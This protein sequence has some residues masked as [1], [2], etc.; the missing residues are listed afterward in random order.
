[1]N[2]ESA[3]FWEYIGNDIA[4]KYD[5]GHPKDWSIGKRRNFLQLMEKE[6]EEIF[7]ISRHK[8]E[9]CTQEYEKYTPISQKTIE[10]IFRTRITNGSIYNKNRFAILLGYENADEYIIK[11]EQIE[12]LEDSEEIDIN[13][14]EKYIHRKA[15]VDYQNKKG[16]KYIQSFNK[17][18]HLKDIYIQPQLVSESNNVY[19]ASLSGLMK[20]DDKITIHADS[21]TGKTTLLKYLAL[22]SKE[23]LNLLFLPLSDYRGDL[24]ALIRNTYGISEEQAKALTLK[25]ETTVL[26]LDAFD[27]IPS[28]ADRIK[29]ANHLSSDNIYKFIL[30]SRSKF[31]AD[32]QNPATLSIKIEDYQLDDIHLLVDKYFKSSGSIISFY[33]SLR[34]GTTYNKELE[35]LKY[36]W[37]VVFI[38]EHYTHG[39][40]LSHSFFT[41]IGLTIFEAIQ[42]KMWQNR[43][44]SESDVKRISIDI[45]G[46]LYPLWNDRNKDIIIEDGLLSSEQIQFLDELVHFGVINIFSLLNEGRKRYLFTI[47]LVSQIFIA[48]WMTSMD[49]KALSLTLSNIYFEPS[50]KKIIAYTAASKAS[51]GQELELFFQGNHLQLPKGVKNENPFYEQFMTLFILKH[52]PKGPFIKKNAPPL[53]ITPF[54]KQKRFNINKHLTDFYKVVGRFLKNNLATKRFETMMLTKQRKDILEYNLLNALEEKMMDYITFL[55]EK[56]EGLRDKFWNETEKIEYSDL[57]VTY[58][59]KIQRIRKS[60]IQTTSFKKKFFKL[61]QTKDLNRDDYI[62]ALTSSP[63]KAP[64]IIQQMWQQVRPLIYLTKF[65]PTRSNTSWLEN[66]NSGDK[67]WENHLDQ[68]Y[69]IILLLRKGEVTKEEIIFLFD[70]LS[71]YRASEEDLRVFQYHMGVFESTSLAK[72]LATFMLGILKKKEALIKYSSL[73]NLTSTST[74]FIEENLKLNTILNEI[75]DELIKVSI[76]IERDLK[77]KGWGGD[78]QEHISTLFSTDINI[79]FKSFLNLKK[80]PPIKNKVETLFERLLHLNQLGFKIYRDAFYHTTAYLINLESHFFL[81]KLT[82]NDYCRT[83]LINTLSNHLRNTDSWKNVLPSPEYVNELERFFL[84][85]NMADRDNSKKIILTLQEIYWSSKEERKY[86]NKYEEH[87]AKFEEENDTYELDQAC[88]YDAFEEYIKENTEEKYRKYALLHAIYNEKPLFFRADNT[89]TYYFS[90]KNYLDAG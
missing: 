89:Y 35:V 64:E 66:S 81:D 19:R 10:N 79:F 75:L 26:L 48:E 85:L 14:Q 62:D 84:K 46:I 32:I 68:F 88:K 72:D 11:K 31:L 47:P 67:V 27:E 49:K 24:I 76:D 65:N 73:Y 40:E 69:Y 21:F 63:Y 57:N 5:M 1:M 7:T 54:F 16:L 37:L 71:C 52:L 13:D 55:S 9:V 25:N 18:Y 8:K 77:T 42:R 51:R 41:N 78:K 53:S 61:I 38:M 6:L 58:E 50:F 28:S 30:T 60:F 90:L 87:I 15:S 44:Y 20:N 3:V 39:R 12:K 56:H 59:L 33:N 22:T 80:L 82:S 34:V 2:R 4:D 45:G 83:T 43:G 86:T 29:L 74:L 70:C 17:S 23:D 36:P